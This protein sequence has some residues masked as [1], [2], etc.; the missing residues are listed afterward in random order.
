MILIILLL[1]LVV[2][3][4]IGG[5]SR[6]SV[7]R[8]SGTQTSSPQE[9]VSSGAPATSSL[10]QLKDIAGEDATLLVANSA[11][12][13][14][15]TNESEAPYKV[16]INHTNTLECSV[17]KTASYDTFKALY[18]DEKVKSLIDQVV[19]TYPNRLVT[20]LSGDDGRNIESWSG[21]T[22]F[23]KFMFDGYQVSQRDPVAQ[24]TWV[25]SIDTCK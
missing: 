24:K 19:I 22:N 21:K 15:A 17:A 11:E 1:V 3:W 7:D 8:T 16:V 20:S 13:R 6:G 23:Y 12:L 4:V 14:E 2:I 5:N 18:E 10:Q 9:P 25:M